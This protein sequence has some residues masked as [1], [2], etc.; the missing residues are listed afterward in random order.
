VLNGCRTTRI[1]C[2]ENCPPGRRTKPQNR[3]HFESEAD[4][5]VAGYR[6]CKVCKPDQLTGPWEPRG[7]KEIAT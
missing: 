5:I 6:A 3:V 4:A 1:Y 2:R 7:V